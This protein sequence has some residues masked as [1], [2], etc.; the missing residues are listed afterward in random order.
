[1]P[2]AMIDQ[3][4]QRGIEVL[5]ATSLRSPAVWVASHALLVLSMTA[6]GAVLRDSCSEL[7]TFLGTDPHR[8]L[9]LD[10]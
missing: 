5:W 6:E 8:T 3:L 10:G 9:S 1:M 4:N 7:L 2:A